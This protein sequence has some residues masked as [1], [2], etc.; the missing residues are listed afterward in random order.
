MREPTH[1]LFRVW[2]CDL[3]D[4]RELTEPIP[5]TDPAY[6]VELAASRERLRSMDR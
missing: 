1:R 2:D 5:D 4:Y 6:A 3:D